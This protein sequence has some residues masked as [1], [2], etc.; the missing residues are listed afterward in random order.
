ML[1]VPGGA[2]ILSIFRL[3]EQMVPDK[4]AAPDYS[5][6]E[7][8][9]SK[10]TNRRMTVGRRFVYAIGKQLLKFILFVLTSSYRFEKVHGSNIVDRLIANKDQAYVPV[11]WHAQQIVTTH[12]IRGWIRRGFKTGF[13]ISASVDGEVPADIARS[14]GAEVIRGSAQETGALVLRD[15]IKLMECGVSIVTNADGPL[16]PPFEIKTGTVI[17]ARIGGAP[18]VPI[19]CAA[20]SAWTMNTWDHFMIPKLFARVVMAVGEPIEVPRDLPMSEIES[21]RTRVQSAMVSLAN[22]ARQQL[23]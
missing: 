4:N 1:Q 18:M 15:A 9:R 12:M 17:M 20:S 5:D 13:I 23:S 8:R 10:S 6:V 19:A 3:Q 22:E 16:G 14:W 2:G 7:M 11:L 21:V